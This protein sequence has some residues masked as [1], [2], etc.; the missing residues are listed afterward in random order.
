MPVE[1]VVCAEHGVQVRFSPQ[2]NTPDHHVLA[3]IAIDISPG[4]MGIE[5]RNFVPRMCEGVIR[6]NSGGEIVLE[7]RAKVR[8]VFL[9]GREP[10][11]MIGLAFISP[12]QDIEQRIMDVIGRFDAD[13]VGKG[14][15]NH[16]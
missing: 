3:A 4:G 13:V 12:P 7:Q 6:I 16:A 2:S 11:Y 9:T 15:T 10:R 5:A 1:F 8:R 14:A